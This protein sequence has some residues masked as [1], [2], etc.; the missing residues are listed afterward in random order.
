MPP[1]RRSEKPGMPGARF[2]SMACEALQHGWRPGTF[3]STR[4]GLALS[5][6]QTHEAWV[7]TLVLF[8]AAQLLLLRF[9]H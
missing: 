8:A 7:W 9:L 4:V 2:S 5:M 1:Q 3:A 6:Q